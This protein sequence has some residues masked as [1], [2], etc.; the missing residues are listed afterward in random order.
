MLLSANKRTG[1]RI[2]IDDRFHNQG[3]VM[4]YFVVPLCMVLLFLGCTSKNPSS[5]VD[6]NPVDTNVDKELL[7]Q[8][9]HDYTIVIYN[10]GGVF[11]LNNTVV[12]TV[13]AM[14]G[15]RVPLG[16]DVTIYIYRA[17]CSQTEPYLKSYSKDVES[18]SGGTV[19]FT[20]PATDI[21][22]GHFDIKAVCH[23]TAWSYYGDGDDGGLKILF[24]DTGMCEGWTKRDIRVDEKGFEILTTASED[25]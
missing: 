3:G 10:N 20:F 7:V 16:E 19:R 15:I 17:G 14:D 12:V 6:T 18:Y 25:E 5:P 13:N 11:Y 9:N 2:G 8:P 23:S 22:L 21:G 4:K 1:A 24:E